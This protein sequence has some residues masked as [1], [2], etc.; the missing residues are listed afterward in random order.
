MSGFVRSGGAMRIRR[1]L[2]RG[3]ACCCA[4]VLLWGAAG[5]GAARA[6]DTVAYNT[7]SASYG[8][9]TYTV[10]WVAADLRDPRLRAE[11]VTAE[12]GIGH[13]ESLESMMARSG[14]VAGVNGT[15]FDA[16]EADDSKRH[17]N[18]LLIASGELVRTG[19]NPAL[20]IRTDKSV[21][22]HPLKTSLE[23]K[24]THGSRSYT[25]QPWGVNTYYGDETPGQVVCY[26]KAYGLEV[27]APNGTK[28]VIEA[29]RI[30]ALTEGAAAIPDEGMVCF[31]GHT[32]NNDRN[33]LPNLHVGDTVELRETAADGQTWVTENIPDAW[34]AA[35]GVGPKL[36]TGGA[37]DL[38]LARD[39][40]DDPKLASAANARS[41]T[42]KDAEGR[43]VM[44]TVSAATLEAAAHV[45]AGLGFVEALNMDGGASSGLY[46]DGAV[47]RAP[48]RLISNAL[49]V[50]RYALPQVQVVAAGRFVSELRGYVKNDATMVPMR[51]I[52]ERMGAEVLWNEATRTVTAKRGATT[53]VLRP[54]AAEA[55][56]NGAA[57]ALP[58]A[59]EIVEG[60]LYMP[61]RFVAET[62]G[63]TVAWDQ[64]LYRVSID[65]K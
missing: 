42:G 34:E 35:I 56:V 43:L 32:G 33:L 57:T 15:F 21:Q 49:V 30:T 2:S 37:V 58:V 16:Y 18:G 17:P 31:I 45:L 46:Y 53:I 22:I 27:A 60:H 28:A 20:G 65:W 52:F 7:A 47:K 11:P 12:G 10:Q 63:A 14:A 8:G 6:D 38:D 25:V 1:L 59:P 39:G 41:F 48:G 61:L 5:E 3:L 13:V 36:V 24:V 51:G 62:L 64:A 26:T 29:G 55:V 9:R 19:N 23:L 40:F 4:L 44:G 54:D 50:K